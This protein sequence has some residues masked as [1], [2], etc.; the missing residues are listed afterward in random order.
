MA[1]NHRCFRGDS[2]VMSNSFL[3]PCHSMLITILQSCATKHDH[4][5]AR[6][7]SFGNFFLSS[8]SDNMYLK[9]RI[10]LLRASLVFEIFNGLKNS[11]QGKPTKA[12]RPEMVPFYNRQLPSCPS[13]FERTFQS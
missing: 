8:S 6:C 3:S 5:S 10:C 1:V 11:S 7:F 12:L 13:A 4:A 2:V 9:Y